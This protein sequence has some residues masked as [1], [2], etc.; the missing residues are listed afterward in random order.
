MRG[1]SWHAS[2]FSLVQ[3]LFLAEVSTSANKQKV[4]G[5]VG[6][7]THPCSGFLDLPMKMSLKGWH[8]SW[9]HCKNHEP[10]L[11]PFVGRLPEYSGTWSEEPMPAE[12]PIVAA[13]ANRVNDLRSC[14][15][16]G[17]YVAV[18]WLA[19]RVMSLKKQ[20]HPGSEYNGVQDPTRETIVNPRPNKVLEL[21]QEMFQNTSSWP[22]AD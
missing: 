15:L 18:H 7:Q 2:K 19:R 20:V 22:P 17:I 1:L 14:S 5:R 12:L 9:F 13:L 4:I 8:K 10:S 6:L 16:T 3:K 21:L 11:L